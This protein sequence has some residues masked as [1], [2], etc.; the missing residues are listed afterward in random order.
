MKKVCLLTGNL[1]FR[2]KK[3]GVHV[4]HE[5]ITKELIKK[6]GDYDIT[7]GCFDSKGE[8]LSLAQKNDSWALPY[9]VKSKM[10]RF[11][12]FFLP[13][14]FFFGKNDVYLCDSFFPILL[15]RSSKRICLV[16]DLMVKIYPEH[17]SI[18]MRIFLN[19]FLEKL[20][21]ADFIVCS[22]NNTK[23]D[24]IKYYNI[25]PEKIMVTYSSWVP[26]QIDFNK[27]MV[28]GLIKKYRNFIFYIGDMRPNKNLLNVLSGFSVFC[29][30]NDNNL[31]FFIAGNKSGQF[32]E[33]QSFVKEKKLQDRVFFLGYINDHEKQYLYRNGLAVLL[34]S[35]YEGFGIP[36]VEGLYY[37]TPVI[38]SNVSSMKEIGEGVSIQVNP[39]DINEIASAIETVCRK[40]F[41]ADCNLVKKKLDKYSF[42]NAACLINQSIEKVL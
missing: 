21:K 40:E 29:Q 25:S 3:T 11:F 5:M 9:I 33:L 30:K 12:S 14:E 13:I 10:K 42:E 39:F 23:K 27:Y 22:S 8:C 7:I 1:I 35:E 4:H 36:I 31:V 26:S 28:S 18:L 32:N 34:V 24:I 38:T 15:N 17:Y 20:K 19:L 6:H 2:E 37:G 16:H 41:I